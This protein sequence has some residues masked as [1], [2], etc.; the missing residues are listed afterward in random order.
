MTDTQSNPASSAFDRLEEAVASARIAFQLDL[1]LLSH[2]HCPLPFDHYRTR[3]VYVY[4]GLLALVYG[5][6]SAFA[7]SGWPFWAPLIGYTVIYWAGV[8][9]L[10]ERWVRRKIVEYIMDDA[11]RLDKLWRY[12]GV[13][14]VSTDGATAKAPSDDW[15]RLVPPQS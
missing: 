4:L 6:T 11:T 14:L 15:R 2:P 8:R 1:R 12:G 3:I 10:A 9:P 5:I 13:A 7:S